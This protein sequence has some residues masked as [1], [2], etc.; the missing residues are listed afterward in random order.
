MS[1]SANEI[2][3]SN[4]ISINQSTAAAAASKTAAAARRWRLG[5]RGGDRYQRR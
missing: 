4:G 5:G 1:V 3:K 2:E